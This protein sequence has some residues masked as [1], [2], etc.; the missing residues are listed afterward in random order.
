VTLTPIGEAEFFDRTSFSR[1]RFRDNGLVW[2]Q[3]G[4]ETAANRVPS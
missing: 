3:N 1:I 2:V 4:E